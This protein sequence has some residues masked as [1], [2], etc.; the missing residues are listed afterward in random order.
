MEDKW[1]AITFIV[2]HEYD[3][4]TPSNRGK[5]LVPSLYERGTIVNENCEVIRIKSQEWGKPRETDSTMAGQTRTG[6]RD[7]FWE[8][9]ISSDVSHHVHY[10]NILLR[11]I[12]K[13]N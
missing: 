8:I 9:L 13:T 7:A 3:L 4:N 6:E 10:I 5:Y 2:C 11:R 1:N 12:S